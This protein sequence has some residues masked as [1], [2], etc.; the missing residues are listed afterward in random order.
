MAHHNAPLTPEGRR[1]LCVRIDAGR[2]IAH[3]A[4]EAH[5]SRRCLAKWYARWQ[6]EGDAGLLDRPSRPANSPAATSEEIADLIEAVRRQTKHG[7]VRIADVLCRVH[8]ITVATSTVHRVLVRR[9]LSRLRDLDPPTGEQ[10]RKVIRYERDAAGDLVHVDVK[11]LGRI[12]NGGGWRMHGRDS[13]AAR[14]SKRAGQGTGRVGY[15]YL[16]TALDDYSRLAYTEAQDN[17][18][19]TTAASFW[20]RSVAFFAEHGV[21]PIRRALTDNGSCYR[22]RA[23]ATALAATNTTH[24]RTRPYT[25][26]TN[27][28]VERFNGTLAREW[29]YVRDYTSETE[30][31]AALAEFLNYYNHQRPHAALGNKP[32]V[33]RTA[34]STFRITVNRPPEPVDL[35]PVQLTINFV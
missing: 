22:S 28:K 16:H 15:L 10:M 32:P 21:H 11:K 33:S 17:E 3:V 5:V 19:G 8:G 24:K 18:R 30:R 2:P 7:P 29:A 20:L 6:A 13:D 9:G 12:P 34:D 1:R 14:A 4:A 23:W 31:L 26:R 35:Y 27:G 25:P